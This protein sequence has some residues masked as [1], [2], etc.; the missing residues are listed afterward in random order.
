MTSDD[1][2]PCWLCHQC[3]VLADGAEMPES[4]RATAAD[5]TTAL[6]DSKTDQ[7][8]HK[9]KCFLN[10]IIPKFYFILWQTHQPDF[11]REAHFAMWLKDP[12]MIGQE[13][14]QDVPQKEDER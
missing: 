13:S 8:I 10:C 12:A 7:T 2:L 1:I 3:S 4:C 5:Q 9:S 11:S 6:Q 14:F